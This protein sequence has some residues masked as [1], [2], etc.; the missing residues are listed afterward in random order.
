MPRTKIDFYQS[1]RDAAASLSSLRDVGLNPGDVSGAWLAET[2]AGSPDD[3]ASTSAS[4]RRIPVEDVGDVEFTGWLAQVALDA[5]GDGS[6]A[7]LS[8]I[9]RDL[10]SDDAE[11]ARVRD[12]LRAGGGVVGV[13]AR[14]AFNALPG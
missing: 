6:T 13:R 7:A 12:T 4:S 5:L 8:A 9:F 14:D 10:T 2:A 3:A 1:R 11:L